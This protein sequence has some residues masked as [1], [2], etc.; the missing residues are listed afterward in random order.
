MFFRL[1]AETARERQFRIS[2][3]AITVFL[4]R[5]IIALREGSLLGG[6]VFDRHE[7]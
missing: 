6:V 5:P 7:A 1:S 3:V 2:V 4:E